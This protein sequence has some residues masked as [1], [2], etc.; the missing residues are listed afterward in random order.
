[1]GLGR[2]FQDARL[3]PEPDRGRDTRRGAGALRRESKHR[4]RRTP[5]A[6]GRRLRAAR[7]D[8]RRRTDRTDGARR[9]PRPVRPGA[10]DR[11]PTCRRPGVP[12]CTPAGGDPVGRTH[13]G[14]RPTRGGSAGAGDPTAPR[15]DGRE[16]RHRRTRHAV[17]VRRVRPVARTR[18]G[19]VIATGSPADVLAHPD[20][21][22]SYLGTSGATIT[23]S[24]GTE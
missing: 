23:R 11:H 10:V 18:T 12:R 2:S 24:G 1:M 7:R 21:I 5:S 4:R 13:L 9:L 14:Y 19:S 8:A 15:R 20:V 16:P 22:E 6:D 3:F 17:R